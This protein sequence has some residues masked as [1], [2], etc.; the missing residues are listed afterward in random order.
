ML[1]HDLTPLVEV[2]SLLERKVKETLVSSS[3]GMSTI[4]SA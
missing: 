2:L 1:I 3:T 4:P